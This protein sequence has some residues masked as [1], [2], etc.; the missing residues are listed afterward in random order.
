MAA[1]V[2]ISEPLPPRRE[3]LA[4]LVSDRV[5]RAFRAEELAGL[6]LATRMLLI[7]LAVIA[8]W[9][10]VWVAPPRVLFLETTLALYALLALLNYR[11]ASGDRPRPWW[12]YFVVAANF[13]LLTFSVV[14]YDL[15]FGGAWPPQMTLRNGTFV[16]FFFVL[17][18]VALSYS[19]RLVLFAGL[20]GA[21]AWSVG[22]WLIARIPGTLTSFGHGPE[23]SPDQRLGQHLDPRFVDLD[24]LI[25]DVIVL[26]IVAGIL[27][28]GVW[29]SRRLVLRQAVAARERAN[30]ARYF[31]PTMVDR[32]A[33]AD[34]PLGAVRAQPVAVLFADIAGFTRLAEHEAPE[35]VIALLRGLHA[36]L[37]AAVFEHQGTLDKY[38]GDG[39]MATFGTP[40]AGPDDAGNA[41]AAARAMLASI[42]A[43]NRARAVQ[44]EPPVHLSVGIHY[45]EVVLGDIGSARHLEFAVIGDAVN[46]ASRLEELSRTLATRLVAS[47]ALVEAVR[48]AGGRQ[49][50]ILAGL[51]RAAPQTLRGRSAP[52]ALWVLREAAA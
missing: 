24:V 10:F 5:E 36:R 48:A 7:A 39:V 51:E 1:S 17:A 46:V 14:G 44:G 42:D 11:V 52:V 15:V 30:L 21:L 34:Q 12:N 2:S 49:A 38:L 16:Y 4:E 8:L 19:P 41:L 13:A 32:L 31:A 33:R 3:Q 50:T 40:D 6:K 25:Q 47:D 20:V 22:A 9:L 28:A 45:G 26:L 27:A 29:R 23:M 43:W 18:I 35:Q 37:E